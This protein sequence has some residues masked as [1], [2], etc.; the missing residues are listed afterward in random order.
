MNR[1]LLNLILIAAM[2]I[3]VNADYK[4]Q[5]NNGAYKT[6]SSILDSI[7]KKN[8]TPSDSLIYYTAELSKDVQHSVS[9][10][11]RIIN[12]H[13]QS[14]FYNL[15]L[16]R[17]AGYGIVTDDTARAVPLLKKII[18]SKDI[19][20]APLAYASLIS[21]YERNGNIEESSKLISDFTAEYPKSEYIKIF[22]AGANKHTT[23]SET[24][25]TVQVGSF[26]LKENAEKLFTSLNKKKY[27]VFIEYKDGMYKVRIGRYKSRDE[28]SRFQQ[29]F[30]KSEG[31]ASW[32]ISNDQ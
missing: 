20:M 32:V 30:Q 27:D 13:P 10:Y 9:L 25:F 7:D 1:K 8:G 28:A 31:T 5:Y 29:I 21:I 17:M 26:S 11:N 4:T 19:S 23:P 12:Q 14:I 18:L 16:Y 15:S 24:Y 6:L 2:F 3:C 22:S